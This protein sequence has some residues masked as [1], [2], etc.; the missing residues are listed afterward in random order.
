MTAGSLEYGYAVAPKWQVA[1]FVDT[2]TAT[3]NYKDR[4]QVGTGVGIRWRTPLG[5]LKIDLAFCGQ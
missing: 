4:W 1:A 5:S 2:G 3:N